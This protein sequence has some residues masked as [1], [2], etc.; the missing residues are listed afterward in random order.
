MGIRRVVA[1]REPPSVHFGI[2]KP[3]INGACAP[4]TNGFLGLL[5]CWVQPYFSVA[6][7][8]SGSLKYRE[9]M[10]F[11]FKDILRIGIAYGGSIIA[12]NSRRHFIVLYL[13]P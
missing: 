7:M 9:K 4:N 2:N 5:Y 8:G 1:M 6:G 10:A 12:L 13:G 11:C 3:L